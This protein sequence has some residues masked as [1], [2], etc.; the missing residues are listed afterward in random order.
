MSPNISR[1]K[2][3]RSYCSAITAGV[4]FTFA[5]MVIWRMRSQRVFG[6]RPSDSVRSAAKPPPS[7]STGPRSYTTPVSISSPSSRSARPTM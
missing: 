6:W 3:S 7:M 4:S 1:V 2:V 5:V